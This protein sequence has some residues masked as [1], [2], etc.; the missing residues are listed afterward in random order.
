MFSLLRNL[1]GGGAKRQTC[2]NVKERFKILGKSSMGSMSKVFRAEDKKLKKIVCLKILDKEKTAKFEARFPGLKKPSEG[3]ISIALKHPHIVETFEIGQTTDGESYLVQEW[4]D[5]NL[6]HNL[7]E[8]NN[9]QLDGRRILFLAQIADA[10]QHVHDQK[11]LHR[12][13]CPR[14]VIVTAKHQCKL[15]DFGLTVPYT[16]DF[17]K[18]GNRTGT[19]QYIAPEIIKRMS[20]DHRIDLYALGVTAYEI[21][22]GD[23]PWGRAESM[24]TLMSHMNHPPADPREHRP[25][26]DEPTVKFLLKCVERDVNKRFQTAA[27][28]RDTVKKLPKKW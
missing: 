27:E 28:F 14:N 11:F 10:I 16:P 21:F 17:C 3:E 12:D 9:V 6:L 18:P 15:I 25:D 26:L 24:D 23:L 4:V 2:V 1:F 22:T 19:V 7:V 13:I 20:T 5:G 8:A